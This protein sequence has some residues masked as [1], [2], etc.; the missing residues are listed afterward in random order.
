MLVAW[1]SIHLTL[2]LDIKSK[3]WCYYCRL[4]KHIY[5]LQQA[6]HTMSMT[7]SSSRTLSICVGSLYHTIMSIESGLRSCSDCISCM[8]SVVGIYLSAFLQLFPRPTSQF[9]TSFSTLF[10]FMSR[11]KK[12]Y[13]QCLISLI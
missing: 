5:E 7:S 12:I 2:T 10:P 9:S 13:A 6:L 4:L 3:L 1:L 8:R 11:P